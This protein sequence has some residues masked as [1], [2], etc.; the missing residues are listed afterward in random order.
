MALH[1]ALANKEFFKVKL[2]DKLP[3]ELLPLVKQANPRKG[4]RPFV[5][6]YGRVT[7][8]HVVLGN[9]NIPVY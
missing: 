7:Y 3:E 2:A 6:S 5:D 9:M 1:I 8:Y 4:Q